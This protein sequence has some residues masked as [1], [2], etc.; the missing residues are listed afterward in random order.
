MFQLCKRCTRIHLNYFSYFSNFSPLWNSRQQQH[1]CHQMT[2][3]SDFFKRQYNITVNP[4]GKS[5]WIN[6]LSKA[7]FST[8]FF[9]YYVVVIL[10]LPLQKNGWW[11]KEFKMRF[12]NWKS[13]GLLKKGLCCV[14]VAYMWGSRNWHRIVL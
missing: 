9:N 7:I 10:V 2:V 13:N 14:N 3:Q 11:W 8:T 4:R 1:F 6:I 5:L 12:S